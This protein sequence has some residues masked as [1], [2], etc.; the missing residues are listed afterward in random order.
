MAGTLGCT[1]HAQTDV[2]SERES[3]AVQTHGSISEGG[4]DIVG[5]QQ[6]L[7]LSVGEAK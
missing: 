4:G 2:H 3:I 7:K 1:S 5:C 6:R